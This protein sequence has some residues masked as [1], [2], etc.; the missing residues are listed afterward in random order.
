[1][2][3]VRLSVSVVS[4]DGEEEE[5]KESNGEMKRRP[6]Q[7]RD[8]IKSMRRCAI[9]NEPFKIASTSTHFTPQSLCRSHRDGTTVRM[10]FIWISLLLLLCCWPENECKWMHWTN[11]LHQFRIPKISRRAFPIAYRPRYKPHTNKRKQ[12]NGSSSLIL[13]LSFFSI[14]IKRDWDYLAALIREWPE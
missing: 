6:I 13:A 5:F 14:S 12:N 10:W 7:I 11:N 2:F 9:L 1:M 3:V 8:L 4:G